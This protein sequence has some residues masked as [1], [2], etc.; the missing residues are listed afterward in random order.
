MIK[1]VGLK[2]MIFLAC[3]ITL[4]LAVLGAY[5]FSIG[6]LLDDVTSQTDTVNGQISELRGK[7]NS[8]KQDMAFVKDNLPKYN[9]LKNSGFF[10]N[11]DRFMISR[12]MEDLRVKSGI[13]SFS[14]SVADVTEIPNTDAEA[15]NYRLINSRIKVDKIVS[16]LDANIYMLAQ[17]MTHVFPNYARLQGMHITRAAEVTEATL[18][19]IASGKPV[20]FVDADL[21]FDWI[22][23]V[24]K[25]AETTTGP[26]GM[27]AG[28]RGQ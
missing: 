9:E 1:L 16:P 13:S 14:F 10:E 24:P 6:P 21:E 15:V 19:D 4:N 2:R 7:I 26:G 18:K 8:I 25:L 27:P 22:T 20:N 11:Q 28:F 3:M 23:M 5:F 12:I 17:E